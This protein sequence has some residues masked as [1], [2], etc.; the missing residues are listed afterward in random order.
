[1]PGQVIV[2]AI[3][4]D[5]G[6]SGSG[7]LCRIRDLYRGAVRVFFRGGCGEISG[8]GKSGAKARQPGAG[9]DCQRHVGGLLSLDPP[10]FGPGG[11]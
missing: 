2:D 7:D 10:D 3:C 8:S 9:P 11:I 1:M 6:V 4:F 5:F